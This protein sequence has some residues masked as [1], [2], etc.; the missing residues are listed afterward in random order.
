MFKTKCTVEW[1][2][3]VLY[4][5]TTCYFLFGICYATIEEV[6]LYNEWTYASR[7]DII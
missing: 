7:G 1:I 2:G 4:K 6:F 5:V 3:N